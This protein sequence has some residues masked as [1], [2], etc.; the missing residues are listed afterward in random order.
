MT[1][2]PRERAMRLKA[3][4]DDAS[5]ANI[6][7]ETRD[8]DREIERAVVFRNYVP[9][10]GGLVRDKVRELARAMKS[11][12]DKA[13]ARQR[14]RNAHQRMRF[15]ARENEETDERSCRWARSRY[16]RRRRRRFERRRRIRRR[17]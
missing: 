9:K 14:M 5:N 3:M 4:R 15:W 12:D 17:Y 2:T 1:E 7:D 6:S 11:D 10:D 8:V 16:R 13:N